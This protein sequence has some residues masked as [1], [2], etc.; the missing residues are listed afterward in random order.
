MFF[1][2]VLLGIFIFTFEITRNRAQIIDLL[3]IFNVLF[4]ICYVISPISGYFMLPNWQEYS[5]MRYSIKG[6]DYTSTYFYYSGIL[7]LF[8]YFFLI[9]SFKFFKVKYRSNFLNYLFNHEFNY[10][11]I[12]RLSIF[13]FLISFIAIL[14]SSFKSGGLINWVVANPRIYFV[15]EAD[16]IVASSW[17]LD[18]ISNF[19]LFSSYL[20][21]GIFVMRNKLKFNTDFIKYSI[22]LCFFVLSLFFSSIVV[23]HSGGRLV[24]FKYFATF[25]IASMYISKNSFS[26][27][28]LFLLIL[29]GGIVAIYGRLVF[30][31]FVYKDFVVDTVNSINESFVDQFYSFINNYTFA[32]FSVINNLK[33]GFDNFKLFGDL[34]TWPFQF[35]PPSFRPDNLPYS[36]KLNTFRLMDL[37]NTG[38]IPSDIVSY[39]LINGHV[40][41]V[42]IVA[43][44]F[45]IVLKILN[46]YSFKISNPISAILYVSVSFVIGFRVM[47]FDPAHLFKGSFDI[48][49]GLVLVYF[50]SRFKFKNV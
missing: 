20:F 9:L 40:F 11:A 7:I 25:F 49:V 35:V 27:I 19:M 48:I 30:K 17:G 22:F 43:I 3:S 44:L 5:V 26:P 6:A 41:G 42:F 29:I 34:F 33:Y 38:I 15:N 32:F 12:Y 23:I 24:L 14:I 8:F 16:D 1:S 10:I 36:T 28:K 45:G 31:Y 13:L 37:K 18:K 46:S 21:W 50:I 4:F 47:Y 39:G 2:Q